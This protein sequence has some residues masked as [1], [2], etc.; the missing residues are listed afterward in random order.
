[1]EAVY[2][3]YT[4]YLQISDRNEKCGEGYFLVDPTLRRGNDNEILPMDCIQCQTV[5]SKNMGP[6]NTWKDKLLVAKESGYN[7]IHFTPVHQIGESDSAYCLSD[8]HNLDPRYEADWNQI[9]DFIAMMKNDWKIL[10]I[11]DIVLNHTANESEWIMN[12]PECSY[13]TINRNDMSLLQKNLQTFSQYFKIKSI[14]TMLDILNFR[15]ISE[16]IEVIKILLVSKFANLSNYFAVF[17]F[18]SI[19]ILDFSPKAFKH[20]NQS[21]FA[22]MKVWMRV[23]SISWRKLNPSNQ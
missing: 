9:K 21:N 14:V 16:N 1:M 2:L 13:N 5:L 18:K 22:E 17:N 19:A 10:S 7:L 12:H 15:N 20:G 23:F 3:H 4:V 8:Q 11:C 6:V